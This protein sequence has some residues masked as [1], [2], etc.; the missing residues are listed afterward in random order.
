MALWILIIPHAIRPLKANVL[1]RTL[2]RSLALIFLSL[3]ALHKFMT[4]N[5]S[6]SNAKDTNEVVEY[7][8]Q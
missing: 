1:H 2:F 4:W 8:N 5:N 3:Y 7:E 6:L